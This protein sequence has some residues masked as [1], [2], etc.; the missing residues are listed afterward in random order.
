MPLVAPLAAFCL[1]CVAVFHLARS[2]ARA[3]DWG[4]PVKLL[5]QGA[6]WLGAVVAHVTVFVALAAA[7]YDGTCDALLDGR[8]RTCSAFEFL[9]DAAFLVTIF[10]LL[11]FVGYAIAIVLGAIAGRR[12]RP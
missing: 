5:A 2:I 10:S 7:E 4:W 9:A 3:A 12:M 6:V 8:K 11:F 1:V